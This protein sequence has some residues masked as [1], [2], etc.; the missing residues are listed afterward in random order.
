VQLSSN[1]YL[2]YKTP[3]FKQSIKSSTPTIP[4]PTEKKTT[5]KKEPPRSPERSSTPEGLEFSEEEGDEDLR[6]RLFNSP[7]R[8]LS[9]S[10]RLAMSDTASTT[11]VAPPAKLDI[12]PAEANGT[13]NGEKVV[14]VTKEVEVIKEADHNSA[15]EPS[16]EADA[17]KET[18][19]MF[20]PI[21]LQL[22][23]TPFRTAPLPRIRSTTRPTAIQA[24]APSKTT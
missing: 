20:Y 8:K 5:T 17:L 22:L 23:L 14:E 7:G 18:E 13:T 15:V 1:V 3:S 11:E 9:R 21:I 10:P 24:I 6:S 12:T 16:K 2:Q 4:T 19:V